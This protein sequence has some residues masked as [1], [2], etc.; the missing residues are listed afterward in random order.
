MLIDIGR[1]VACEIRSQAR[2]VDQAPFVLE[3]S[4]HLDL[5]LQSC[6]YMTF[7]TRSVD[8]SVFLDFK[9]D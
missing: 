9:A 7:P 8:S 3:R 2:Q 5:S 1:S 6:E 4:L